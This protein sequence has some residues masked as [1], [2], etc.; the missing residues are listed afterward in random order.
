MVSVLKSKKGD[1]PDML[2]FV[3][4]A[5]IFAIVL[6]IFAFI[7]PE[8]TDGLREGGVNNS[9]A[10]EGAIQELQTFGTVGLQ[11]GFFFVFIGLAIGVL[12][13]AFFIR[14]H[15]IFI[16]LY[17]IF[18]GLSI[19]IG[20]YLGY[21]FDQFSTNPIFAERLADQTLI[22]F[23]MDNLLKFVLGIGALSIIIIFAKYRDSA[24]GPL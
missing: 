10:G 18:L 13:S 2:V 12:V 6:F 24:G 17:I 23:V 21:M 9:V 19:F 14:T 20:Y 4:T 11:R 3:I 15:P 7:I 5:V 1:L 22:T 16:F 8:I